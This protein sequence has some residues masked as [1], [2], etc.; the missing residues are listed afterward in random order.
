[1]QGLPLARYDGAVQREQ[2]RLQLRVTENCTNTHTHSRLNL[3]QGLS[4]LNL[5]QAVVAMIGRVEASVGLHRGKE[6]RGVAEARCT[7]HLRRH[8]PAL[9]H[10]DVHVQ[11]G[12]LE[13]LESSKRC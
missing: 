3:R 7:A 12:L 4:Y 5:H 8:N 13:G 1:M 2:K 11:E 9:P 10:G 6:R